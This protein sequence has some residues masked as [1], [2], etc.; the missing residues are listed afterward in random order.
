MSEK[1]AGVE[2][3][4]Q[5]DILCVV[6][7]SAQKRKKVMFASWKVQTIRGHRGSTVKEKHGSGGFSL[8][9]VSKKLV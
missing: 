8:D 6:S 7:A 4:I 3:S 9:V 1:S 2:P 5:H